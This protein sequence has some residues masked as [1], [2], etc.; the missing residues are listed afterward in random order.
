MGKGGKGEEG[1][2]EGI[3]REEETEEGKEQVE[4]DREEKREGV[5]VVGELSSKALLPGGLCVAWDWDRT[6]GERMWFFVCFFAVL[7]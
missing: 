2:G 5:G 1:G 7:L 3:A 4:A 6:K